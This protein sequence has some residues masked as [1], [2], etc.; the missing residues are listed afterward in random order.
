VTF[1]TGAIGLL[2]VAVIGVFLLPKLWAGRQAGETTLDW[3]AL[4]DAELSREEPL[5]EQGVSSLRSD[6]ELRVFDELQEGQARDA[7]GPAAPSRI[8]WP[9][10]LFLVVVMLTLPPVLYYFLGSYE[11]VVITEELGALDPSSRDSVEALVESIVKRSKARPANADYHSILGDYYTAQ[12]AHDQALASYEQLLALFPESPEV[13]ARAAQAEYLGG[14]RS[15]STRARLRAKAALAADPGQR[16]ALGTLGMAAFEAGDYSEAV[17]FWERLLALEP[18]GSE[19]SQMLATLIA[20]ARTQGN[21]E[22]GEPPALDNNAG[23]GAITVSVSLPEE[24]TETE[25]V[26][27]VV[28]R[29]AGSEQRMPTAV[30]RRGAKEL[31]FSVTLDDSNSMTGQTLSTLSAVDI[32]VQLSPTGQPG[33]QNASWVAAQKGVILAPGAEVVLTL[34][35][36]E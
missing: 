31:P 32:E 1:F 24:V 18:P 19:G 13:L 11:D 3:L 10:G 33:R 21:L 8:A 22:V 28:A 16:T 4:R 29:P 26:V 15:L 30:A 36:A 12:G 20:E 17:G 5:L 6:A 7:E 35:A 9:V 25:G 14:D 2:V 27:F 34:K 23:L